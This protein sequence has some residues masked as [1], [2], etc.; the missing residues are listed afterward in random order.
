MDYVNNQY[1]YYLIEQ[2]N[3][4]IDTGDI[5]YIESALKCHCHYTNEIKNMANSIKLQLLTEYIGEICIN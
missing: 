5:K 2:I 3:M 4:A 1:D